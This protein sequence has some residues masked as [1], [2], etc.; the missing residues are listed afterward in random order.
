MACR[1]KNF[2]NTE[3][4][5]D[6]IRW[7][8]EVEPDWKKMV[9]DN[10]E[11]ADDIIA[12]F[13]K[14]GDNVSLSSFDVHTGFP[15]SNPRKMVNQFFSQD[16]TVTINYNGDKGAINRMYSGFRRK[17]VTLSIFDFDK[18]MPIRLS[19]K[20]KNPAFND[21]LNE[22]IYNYK[23]DLI[24]N[25]WK[26]VD[27][28]RKTVFESPEQFA[29]EQ[30]EA[31]TDFENYTGSKSSQLYL[32]ARD[33]FSIL[34]NF[35]IL[36]KNEAPFIGVKEM[37]ANRY[38]AGDKYTYEGANTDLFSTWTT[39]EEVDIN[40]QMGKMLATIIEQFPQYTE[41]GRHPM[42]D[43][44]I[45]K[46]EFHQVMTRFKEWLM[47]DAQ[48]KNVGIAEAHGADKALDTKKAQFLRLNINNEADAIEADKIAGELFDKFVENVFGKS[49][50]KNSPSRGLVKGIQ[51]M[52]H[53]GLHD[54][55][56]KAIWALAAKTEKNLAVST[57]MGLGTLSD[58]LIQDEYKS[59]ALYHITDNIKNAIEKFRF[60]SPSEYLRIKNKYGI[61]IDKDDPNTVRI[62]KNFKGHKLGKP[63]IFTFDYQSQRFNSDPSVK[64]TITNSEAKI[65]IEEL[66][67]IH[68]PDNYGDVLAQMYTDV[69]LIKL[70]S[71]P[72]VLTLLA[73]DPA[74]K[75]SPI[76]FPEAWKNLNSANQIDEK[77]S[78]L[79][80]APYYTHLGKLST[81]FGLAWRTNLASTL[82]NSFGNNV[83]AYTLTSEIYQVD[84]LVQR[85]KMTDPAHNTFIGNPVFDQM[86]TAVGKAIVRLDADIN[87][88]KKAAGQLTTTELYTIGI[89]SDFYKR[90]K[91]DN[92]S[93]LYFQNSC[94]SDKN[95]HFLI[96]YNKEKFKL[97]N[98]T[99]LQTALDDIIK[100]NNAR[101]IK[102]FEDAIFN[103]RKTAYTK[104]LNNLVEDYIKAIN[105]DVSPELLEE[106]QDAQMALAASYDL[107]PEKSK[108]LEAKVKAIEAKIKQ[109]RE[110]KY[111]A[112][113]KNLTSDKPT[114]LAQLKELATN[115]EKWKK[116]FF[117]AGLDY[118]D[119]LHSSNGMF[120]ETL[121][122]H[123]NM[124]VLSKDNSAFKDRLKKQQEYF[125]GDLQD[126][127]SRVDRSFDK[128]TYEQIR[129]DIGDSWFNS[130]T[131][132]MLL[133][134]TDKDG[135]IILNPVLQ[136]YFYSDIL[137]SN[138]FNEIIFG[139][140][141]FH[142][143]KS[144]AKPN[145]AD[146]LTRSEASRLS[147][148]YKRTVI[149]GGTTHS[150]Y[151]AKYGISSNI[152]FAVVKDLGASVFN[153][154]G[155]TDKVDSMDGSGLSSPY[156]AYMENMSLY[157]AKVGMD[158]KTIFGDNDSRYGT[159]TLLKWA[160]FAITND[161]RR[162]SMGSNISA[163]KL[164]KK[165]HSDKIGKTINLSLYYRPNTIPSSGKHDDRD[166]SRIL[167]EH[168]YIYRFDPNTGIYYRLDSIKME[169][170]TAI[171]SE[172]A[173]TSDGRINK[174]V[175]AKPREVVVDTLYDLDQV[176]GGAYAMQM[177][178]ESKSLG[179]S[180]VNIKL[181][182]NIICNEDLKDKFTGYLVNKSGIKVGARN[183]NSEDVF[184][185]DEPLMTT[186]MSLMFGGV[187]MNADHEIEGETE[188]TEMSQM[189]SSLIQN[190]Y[191]TDDVMDIYNEI[192]EVVVDSLKEIN[193]LVLEGN[194][195]ALH[196]KLGKDLIDDFSSG[197]DTMGLAQSYLLKAA[198]I[199][200]EN[201]DA[202]VKIPFSD[203]T[204]LGAFTANI[205]SNINKKGIRRKYA[206]I[207]SVLVPSR[208]MI[209]YYNFGGYQMMYDKLAQK[210]GQ[211]KQYAF[212][213]LDYIT[214][215]VINNPKTG[216]ADLNGCTYDKENK[217]F[218]LSGYSAKTKG[219]IE[220]EIHP[221][222]NLLNDR[223][224]AD[225]GD[226]VII[227]YPDGHFELK[228]LDNYDDYDNVRN[229][230]KYAGCDIFK[231]S[232]KPVDL[233]QSDTTFDLPGYGRQFS[234]Y[235]LASVRANH[236]LRQCY[237][238]KT[239]TLSLSNLDT[240]DK[241]DVINFALSQY[242]D[243]VPL[244]I[245]T[246]LDA[247]TVKLWQKYLTRQTKADLKSLDK[248]GRLRANAIYE[249]R[250]DFELDSNLEAEFNELLHNDNAE[251]I[252][253]SNKLGFEVTDDLRKDFDQ[254]RTS[255]H[256]KD[257]AKQL[258]QDKYS[259]IPVVDFLNMYNV[260]L[261]TIPT[262][263]M[264]D[265]YRK[266]VK[267]SNVNTRFA[268]VIMGRINGA[269]LGLRENDS[270]SDVLERG[271]DFF[272]S[273][274]ME[275]ESL[276]DDNVDKNTYDLVVKGTHGEN[277][278]VMLRSL[279]SIKDPNTGEIILSEDINGWSKDNTTFKE[280]DE[281][282][283]YK[284]KPLCVKG[285]KEFYSRPGLFNQNH[286][287]VIDDLSELKEILYS[288]SFNRIEYNYTLNN[289][290]S[291]IKHQY[292]RNFDDAG[293]LTKDLELHNWDFIEGITESAQ[294][295]D[296]D[297]MMY[298]GIAAKKGMKLSDIITPELIKALNGDQEYK[299]D[300][301][302][303]RIARER[304]ASFI[305]QLEYI[306]ARIPT[307]SMQSFMGL[308]L[309]DF[310]NSKVNEVYVP[311]VQTWLEGSDYDIDKLYIMGMELNGKGR[312]PTNSKLQN[313]LEANLS[314]A[315]LDEILNL[316]PATGV[317]YQMG[318]DD[319]NGLSI[320]EV[321]EAIAL[322][323]VSALN[324]I[325]KTKQETVSFQF[326]VDEESRRK[327][328]DLLNKHNSTR[329]SKF[330][331]ESALKNSIV[332]RITKLLKHP[333]NQVL[334]HA[335]ISMDSFRDIASR[336]TLGKKEQII[337][338]DN[339][340]TKFI[341]QT[342]NMVGKEVIGI[343]AV[344]L[345]VFFATST[346]M[347]SRVNDMLKAL[348]SEDYVEVQN[349][350]H[351][352]T[353]TD[354]IDGSISTIANLNLDIINDFLDDL[355]PEQR[356]VLNNNVPRFTTTIEELAEKADIID[357]AE[358]ISQLLSC[359]TD[360]AKELILA[361]INAT[362]DFADAWSLLVATC[363]E[364]DN[365]EDGGIAGLMMSPA[366][367]LVQ[368]YTKTN[369]FTDIV[370]GNNKK[371]AIEFVLGKSQL[372]GIN[373]RDLKYIVGAYRTSE[374]DN[375]CFINKLLYETETEGENRG[376]LILDSNG[377]PIPRHNPVVNEN[378][379]I[380]GEGTEDGLG[381]FDSAVNSD[382]DRI[383][384][385]IRTKLFDLFSDPTQS[386]ISLEIA[387][388]LMD[389][390]TYLVE[391][392]KLMEQ[393][394]DDEE[395]DDRIEEEEE[396]NYDS[397]EDSY[398]EDD[399]EDDG[400]SWRSTPDFDENSK[401]LEIATLK[402]LKNLEA[403]FREYVIPKNEAFVNARV[404]GDN[405]DEALEKLTQ[406]YT[407]VLPAVEE[408]TILGAMLGVNQGIKTNL[409]DFYAKLRRVETFINQKIK[410][411]KVEVDEPFDII[412]FLKS[413][414]YKEKWIDK[415]EGI[416]SV[417]NVL[418]I[419]DSVPNFKNMYQQNALAFELVQHS[420]RNK[421]NMKLSKSILD[422]IKDGSSTR[423]KLTSDQWDIMDKYVRDL[424]LTN[425]VFGQNIQIQLPANQ[426]YYAYDI[427]NTSYELF[428]NKK[429]SENGGEI[430]DPEKRRINLS[431]FAG[432]A[433]FVRYF[434]NTLI[435][436]LSRR[437]GM[438][439]AFFRNL[440]NGFQFSR[441]HNQKIHHTKLTVNA[442]LADSNSSLGATYSNILQD[443]NNIATDPVTEF[444]II[445]D[446]Q[447]TNP[448]LQDV[449]FLYNT[450]VYK[451]AFTESGFTRLFESVV[452]NDDNSLINNYQE[453]LANLDSNIEDTGSVDQ[454][455]LIIDKDGTFEWGILKGNINDLLTRLAFDEK[456]TK[457]FNIKLERD[458]EGAVTRLEFRD[459][460][461]NPIR[462][463]DGS[464]K[465]GLDI[466]VPNAND[467]TLWMPRMGASFD[468]TGG[469]ISGTPNENYNI[470]ESN[471][472]R[473][474]SKTVIQE[475]TYQIAN[476]FGLK[477]GTN[478]REDHIIYINDK[479]IPS[480]TD[481][482]LDPNSSI[483]QFRNREDWER[484]SRAKG[485]VHNGKVFLNTDRMG[486]D[487][488]M[489][490]I[491]HVV[492]ACMKFNENSELRK[493]YYNALESITEFYRTK[494]RPIY[495]SI[496]RSY[497]G[498]SKNSDFK[499]ELFIHYLTNR[500]S[501]NFRKQ[502]GNQRFTDDIEGDISTILNEIFKVDLPEDV[503]L[504]NAA[505]TSVNDFMLVFKSKLFDE[506]ANEMMNRALLSE[507]LKTIKRILI[508][509]S[510]K[511][512]EN[513]KIIYDC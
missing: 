462:L 91:N 271:E 39:K 230:G 82:K 425:W 269:Q 2:L 410:D 210:I 344:A 46:I 224:Q 194:F 281:N 290:E 234:I 280:L 10:F 68:I 78:E 216:Y 53:S 306:G 228:V 188:V 512:D 243:F 303:T 483:I 254:I 209:Q 197:K 398:Q 34:K 358:V 238:K 63:V 258:W 196:T 438:D 189:I 460:F 87:G 320:A 113:L 385:E 1:S 452:F 444:T 135:N 35:D 365:E 79:K 180:D 381:V 219:N 342:Q 4:Q 237:N 17:M 52:M 439:H 7:W 253:L 126:A 148:S 356:F 324:K 151:P 50:I 163:E 31:L 295:Y 152:R 285:F 443:F 417:F 287:L 419:I 208:G 136:A 191:F 298:R 178:P 89:L 468:E 304:Y 110:I 252:I 158:K 161:R 167:S 122:A 232:I 368:K 404:N 286:L 396:Q 57:S 399:E 104:I 44:T 481:Y 251:N 62:T 469:S 331:K 459:M 340:T 25:I 121:E 99:N 466:A 100:N 500:F 292:N 93:D 373:I 268:E 447:E 262:I 47:K 88:Q 351:D 315:Q 485:F 509:N 359:A 153:M 463:E 389:H 112:I 204:L 434:E 203:P 429:V 184:F 390:I 402:S 473:F 11:Y 426:E 206:G 491:L 23:T 420:F 90:L 309:V 139:R 301:D 450:L 171:I 263:V 432:C 166:I 12:I 448:T 60:T 58:K 313:D 213:A 133:S 490:E 169:G 117:N 314:D 76:N 56:K 115:S 273:R 325:A 326:D 465:E 106:F 190:G 363:H 424:I 374:K 266:S 395:E 15:R 476:R 437:Y 367:E 5:L 200:N 357:A 482:N 413:D 143:N 109:E 6:D 418:K 503:N 405:L 70:F 343:T 66:L 214:K 294:H 198:K 226:T 332:H 341:M 28:S 401:V 157:D 317:T 261:E 406:F 102:V 513:N 383:T 92:E 319:E 244:T 339:P 45:S 330:T 128:Q 256:G 72:I 80:L 412:N 267:V 33:A 159:P 279:H 501:D 165:M 111:G 291:L 321:R 129:K 487:T 382:G 239:K 451:N 387:K 55:I 464:E 85:M 505:N 172:T 14:E 276:T 179:Y 8:R 183:I 455:K 21:Y 297:T 247:N 345:K 145:D 316:S 223:H 73:S 255:E 236:Y 187:Q 458:E 475:V 235:D 375:T 185:N 249:Y 118:T 220:K 9:R 174:D 488:A 41:D 69:D 37:Y 446:G 435:P 124:Y 116:L 225:M 101:G 388:I 289:A 142:P 211:D 348:Q 486:V 227:A 427:N 86:G 440:T 222:I 312:I 215:G 83:A 59:G 467:W 300:K 433:S 411:R 29:N 257:I 362:T 36:L 400:R 392:K 370:K 311:A 378:W 125:L 428:P 149:A 333:M 379:L 497:N 245:D 138:S 422:F 176:F 337:T 248:K 71:C 507:K 369:L 506:D 233:R 376:K 240:L 318:M 496:L 502:F 299:R 16:Q 391:Q 246:K 327:F 431:T 456:S 22:G 403:Y 302:I 293:E 231:W 217:Q 415:Y 278:Y 457:D 470:Q 407:N 49:E 492:S 170:N 18:D 193:G 445:K 212:T 19:K 352:I 51:Q 449:L 472:Y 64:S 97:N 493:K 67:N 38:E 141:F 123:I 95:T 65:F 147:A 20:P 397:N 24:N 484:T 421:L 132:Q 192:G 242:K 265:K 461:G 480:W 408:Q 494:N 354:P 137:L 393:A 349:A 201:P 471:R 323:D 478:P 77:K 328:I 310:T 221:F 377:N 372:P 146:Y 114:Q 495:T 130:K 155:V 322:R 156:Q 150:F 479:T 334:G 177:N 241:L 103:S 259:N 13:E 205:I 307:Q 474:N 120:N 371:S 81:F 504:S 134:K 32:D 84:K 489:H 510:F 30:A 264:F 288:D 275:S 274:I 175:I 336:S 168:D 436:E 498:N 386:E 3:E 96:P 308:K 335:P 48:P 98:S 441:T 229:S 107:A 366:F 202:N 338:T 409:N 346:F 40:G 394:T 26:L 27:T 477:V 140:T 283:Y 284:D 353:F 350:L 154:M 162:M 329:L 508:H 305:K 361:K 364:L 75:S 423:K 173:V 454:D 277:L 414:S 127:G 119:E 43:L 182:C 430:A 61:E 272:K 499:E 144:G 74:A 347:N 164:F 355:T 207:A 416:K 108:S 360:N 296:E 131:Q 105:N 218:I 442:M 511:E 380:N 94:F 270:V 54:D 384:G 260:Y 199:L 160:V 186:K 250:L 42:P 453:Y 181:G 195:E 282:I